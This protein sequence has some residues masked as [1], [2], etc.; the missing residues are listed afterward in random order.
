MRCTHAEKLI[1]LYV[2][3]DL[4]AEEA[5]ATRRHL[6][7]CA[8]CRDLVTEFEV[9]YDWLHGFASPDFDEATLDGVRDA[10]M[11]EIN[12]IENRPGLLE[13]ILPGWNMRFAFAA[14]LALL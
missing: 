8:H 2:G 4:A 12:R 14:S 10:V 7:S 5:E 9:S 6:E 3:N 1:P 11:G 13:W